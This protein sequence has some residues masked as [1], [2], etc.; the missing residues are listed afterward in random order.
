MFVCLFVI[1]L[2]NIAN[3]CTQQWMFANMNLIDRLFFFFFFFI[4][5][6][7]LTL[8]CSSTYILNYIVLIVTRVLNIYLSLSLSLC[9]TLASFWGEH[10]HWEPITNHLDTKRL[11]ILFFFILVVFYHH[12]IL[13]MMSHSLIIHSNSCLL[14][15]VET[16]IYFFLFVRHFFAN[17]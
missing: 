7:W 11:R 6:R 17:Y 8:V 13:S 1:S 16:E 4:R 15:C 2:G 12:Y 3:T 9:V 10:H 14:P 5:W